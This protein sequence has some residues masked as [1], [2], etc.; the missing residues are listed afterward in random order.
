MKIEPHNTTEYYDVA[1]CRGIV[2]LP[3]SKYAEINNPDILE[4]DE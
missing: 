3:Y 4:K 1:E 2:V